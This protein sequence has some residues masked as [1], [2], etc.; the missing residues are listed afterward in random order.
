[1]TLTI[2]FIG[3]LGSIL[4]ISTNCCRTNLLSANSDDN[5]ASALT[6]FGVSCALTASNMRLTARSPPNPLMIQ[7]DSLTISCPSRQEQRDRTTE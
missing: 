2:G 5:E 1:M 6:D 3:V 4:A 7:M